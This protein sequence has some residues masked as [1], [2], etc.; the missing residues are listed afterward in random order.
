MNTLAPRPPDPTSSLSEIEAILTKIRTT[1]TVIA[2]NQ[3][4]SLTPELKASIHNLLVQSALLKLSHATVLQQTEQ[5]RKLAAADLRTLVGARQKLR[6]LVYERHALEREIESV[7]TQ[8]R[9]AF[10]NLGVVLPLDVNADVADTVAADLHTKTE[11]ALREE[12]EK[13][14]EV[15]RRMDEVKRR[16]EERSDVLVSVRGQL[17][18]LPEAVV[19]M[20]EVVEPIKR[21]LGVEE[22]DG[23]SE[24]EMKEVKAL[25]WQLYVL[26]REAMAYRTSYAGKIEVT[27]VEEDGGG[28]E[29]YRTCGRKVRVEII[30]GTEIEGKRLVVVWRYHE[31]LKVVSVVGEIEGVEGDVLMRLFPH[32]VGVESPNA[33][34]RHLNDGR[35]RWEADKAEGG[36]PFMWANLVCAVGCLPRFEKRTE[37]DVEVEWPGVAAELSG[38]DR[39][40]EVVEALHGRLVSRVKLHK[41]LE[42]LATKRRLLV[43]PRELGME[44]EPTAVVGDFVALPKEHWPDSSCDKFFQMWCMVVESKGVKLNVLIGLLAQYPVDEPEFRI[45]S[46]GEGGIC[47]QDME[48][49]AYVVN[50]F[51]M[52][53]KV[54]K[55]L[56]VC[57][58]IVRLLLGV[59]LL[60]KRATEGD[61]ASKE[62]PMSLNRLLCLR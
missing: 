30:G 48:E 38:H 32:D 24:A 59:D 11:T 20:K 46:A 60:V 35:F 2:Q 27:V 50:N 53:S 21:F 14:R 37:E 62:P 34:N 7:R 58:R 12:L 23:V 9:T 4:Q 19:K 40:K 16:T 52:S 28:K 18:R 36:R 22:G 26:A 6:T 47:E 61:G 17:Q 51:E 15:K 45:S 13:R 31:E 25:P 42:R 57:G 49:L 33:G 43:G 41:Q 3:T 8:S 5:A 55:N 56:V 44:E 54:D 10:D 29:L 1:L 39:F